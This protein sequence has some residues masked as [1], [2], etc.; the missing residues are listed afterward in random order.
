MKLEEGKMKRG[1]TLCLILTG[2][3]FFGVSLS[4]PQGGIIKGPVPP[5]STSPAMPKA[6]PVPQPVVPA[7]PSIQAPTGAGQE[8]GVVNPRTGDFYP[9][10]LGG[11]MNPRTGDILPKVE[12]GYLNPRTG[13]VVPAK[14]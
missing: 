6:A 11:V 12:G 8:K 14:P 7:P 1:V 5:V 3:F 9:G 13:E 4:F 2:I 10:V